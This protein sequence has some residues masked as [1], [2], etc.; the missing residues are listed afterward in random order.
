MEGRLQIMT[1]VITWGINTLAA[2]GLLGIVVHAIR[3]LW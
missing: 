3:W 1:T 2:V